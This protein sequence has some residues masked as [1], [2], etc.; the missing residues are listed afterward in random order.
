MHAKKIGIQDIPKQK[1]KTILSGYQKKKNEQYILTQKNFKNARRQLF[2]TSRRHI[3]F[4]R[5]IK[6]KKNLVH[7]GKCFI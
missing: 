6:Q 4:C 7:T 2:I 5:N 3:I 1:K